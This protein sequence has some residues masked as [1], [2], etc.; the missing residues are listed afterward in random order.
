MTAEGNEELQEKTELLRTFLQ[1]TDFRELRRKSEKYLAEGKN[2]KFAVYLKNGA[3]KHD[4]KV[5]TD[6]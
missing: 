5:T 2:V 1:T 6:S 4:M 3:V